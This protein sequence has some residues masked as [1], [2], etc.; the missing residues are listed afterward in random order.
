MGNRDKLKE[1]RLWLWKVHSSACI[2][3]SSKQDCGSTTSNISVSF[4]HNNHNKNFFSNHLLHIINVSVP[5]FNKSMGRFC[6]LHFDDIRSRLVHTCVYRLCH[7]LQHVQS[8]WVIEAT[9]SSMEVNYWY[10]IR[11]PNP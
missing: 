3:M 8:T 9:H 1:K 2:V 10:H 11:E 6:F 4:K 5:F 7:L